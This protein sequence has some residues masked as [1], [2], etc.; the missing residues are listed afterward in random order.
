MT[1]FERA[2]FMGFLVDEKKREQE[3]LDEIKRN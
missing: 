2:A 1:Q 3:H